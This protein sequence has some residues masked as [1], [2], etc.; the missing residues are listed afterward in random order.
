[1]GRECRSS[2]C[3]EITPL[4]GDSVEYRGFTRLIVKRHQLK[5]FDTDARFGS[6]LLRIRAKR[7]AKKIGRLAITHAESSIVSIFS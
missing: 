6:I 2:D 1:M 5:E 3:Y 4:G 7:L